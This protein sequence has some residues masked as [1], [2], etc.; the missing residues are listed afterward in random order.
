MKLVIGLKSEVW[1]KSFEEYINTRQQRLSKNDTD[2]PAGNLDRGHS[3]AA[4]ERRKIEVMTDALGI[5]LD[6]F[7]KNGSYFM[8]M[9]ACELFDCLLDGYEASYGKIIRNGMFADVPQSYLVRVR[10]LL[11]DALRDAGVSEDELYAELHFY[12]R[13][14]D[15]PQRVFATKLSE[16]VAECIDFCRNHIEATPE[17]WDLVADCIELQYLGEIKPRLTEFLISNIKEQLQVI[18]DDNFGQG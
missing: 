10:A 5:S 16:P 11:F 12:E 13:K 1:F 14:T 18:R 15:C 3:Y 6:L 7:K 2:D 8:T 9:G 17:E 4:K